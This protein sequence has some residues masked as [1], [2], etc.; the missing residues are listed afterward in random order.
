MTSWL[1]FSIN[2]WKLL[3]WCSAMY[4]TQ[5]YLLYA[6]DSSSTRSLSSMEVPDLAPSCEYTHVKCRGR[7][8]HIGSQD[9]SQCRAIMICRGGANT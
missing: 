6:L 7:E 8:V 2:K 3:L 5:P 9:Q 1:A 4:C